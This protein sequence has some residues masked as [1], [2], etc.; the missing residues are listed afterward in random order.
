MIASGRMEYTGMRSGKTGRLLPFL[1]WKGCAM[2]IRG[3]QEGVGR[4]AGDYFLKRIYEPYDPADGK[5]I[6]IDRIWPR[7][8]SK[9]EAK[10]DLWMKEIAPS[11]ELRKWFG[12]KRERFQ[13]FSKRYVTELETEEQKQRLVRELMAMAKK[14]KVT[15]LYGA[16]DQEYN[17]A[18]VLRNF[19]TYLPRS[20]PPL[21]GV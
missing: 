21:N 2:I 1:F 9:T 6:L 14:E 5:R 11:P 16:K 13:E 15:L 20:L 7:G 17:H 4:M 19:L 8:I 10:I 3:F 12:H 18:V